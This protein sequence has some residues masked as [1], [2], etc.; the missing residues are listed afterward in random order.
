[1]FEGKAKGGPLNGVKLTAPYEWD[2]F[3]NKPRTK[4]E[5]PKTYLPGR[6][7]WKFADQLWQWEPLPRKVP[8]NNRRPPV[9]TQAADCQRGEENGT[10]G[11]SA[12]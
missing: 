3:V 10:T 8:F 7:V 6:Y 9:F 2:G 11:Q 5:Q 1:M 4:S 12:P